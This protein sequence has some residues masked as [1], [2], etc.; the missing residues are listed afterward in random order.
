DWL[1]SALGCTLSESLALLFAG[2]GLPTNVVVQDLL[3][4][5]ALYGRQRSG[6]ASVRDM[7]TSWE[8]PP[9]ATAKI[10]LRPSWD[11]QAMVT[12]E[13][14]LTWK[15]CWRH[16]PVALWFKDLKHAAIAADIPVSS[17]QTEGMQQWVLVNR[18]EVAPVLRI[19]RGLAD[20]REKT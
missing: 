6:S 1:E 7:V 5:V 4:G 12:A 14:K 2:L 3:A 20:Q 13:P 8:L 11:R 16:T 17:G 10:F 19:L 9:G 18:T 15:A